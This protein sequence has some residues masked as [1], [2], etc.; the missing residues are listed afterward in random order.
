MQLSRGQCSSDRVALAGGALNTLMLDPSII[1]FEQLFRALP[2]E[3]MFNPNVRP[4]RP[5]NF[6]IGAFRVDN[7]MALALFDLRPDIYRFSGIDPG[8][9]VP[10][11]ARRFAAVLGFDITIDQRHTMGNIQYQL[12]SHPID[13]SGG[14]AFRPATG[15][16]DLFTQPDISAASSFASPAGSGDSLQPQRPHRFGAPSIPFMILARSG[17][18]VQL[19][20]VVFRPIPSPIAFI[21]YG[22]TGLLLPEQTLEAYLKCMKPT[23]DIPR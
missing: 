17:Q 13:H 22:M 10:V 3:G 18:T 23:A 21:E 2:E 4:S 7:T 8:D 16:T 19:R 6:E 9:S 15:T 11:E 1:P 14:Q 12:D 20:V 5:F